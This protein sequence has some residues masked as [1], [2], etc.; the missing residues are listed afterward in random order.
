MGM[1]DAD[2]PDPGGTPDTTPLWRRKYNDLLDLKRKTDRAEEP[3]RKLALEIAHERSELCDGD[4]VLFEE[5]RVRFSCEGTGIYQGD[6]WFE[7]FP[8]QLLF[9]RAATKMRGL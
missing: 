3:F 9:E 7:E 1:D 6:Q 2:V 5:K 4:I 8:V